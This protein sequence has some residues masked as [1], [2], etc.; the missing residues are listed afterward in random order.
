MFGLKCDHSIICKPCW[1]DYLLYSTT[2]KECIFLTWP[3][4]KCNE[5][6]PPS[7][8]SI[9]LK[10]NYNEQNIA[11]SPNNLKYQTMQTTKNYQFV[12]IVRNIMIHP[13]SQI[14]Q[15]N[16]WSL[17]IAIYV[18]Q[19]CLMNMLFNYYYHNTNRWNCWIFWKVI[20]SFIGGVI[21]NIM[22]QPLWIHGIKV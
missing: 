17:N 11:N 2:T 15:M 14:F 4:S 13:L 1:I 20:I 16:Y 21:A 6:I 22:L 8:C 7:V 18:Y 19:Q 10:G 12:Q 9:F 5:S 3:I